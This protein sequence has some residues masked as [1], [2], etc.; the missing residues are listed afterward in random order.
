MSKI[1]LATFVVLRVVAAV[2]AE[3]TEAK[4]SVYTD[5]RGQSPGAI[6]KITPAD[7]PKPYVSKSALNHARLV[8]RPKNAWPQAAPGFKVELYAEGLDNPRLIRTAPNGDLFLAE[9]EPG[10]IRVLRAASGA[11]KPAVNEVYASGLNKPFGIAF[12]PPGPH[13]RYVYIGDTD[14]VLRFPYQEGDRKARSAPEVIVPDIPS[15]GRLRGGGHWTRD[16]AFSNDGKRM[17]VSVGSHSNDAE[18]PNVSERRR[19]DI[20]EYNPD[21]TGFRFYATGIR[22]AVGIAI[23]PGTGDLWASVNERDD[24]GDNLVPDYITRVQ[25]GGFYG[26]PWFYMGNHYDPAHVGKHPE[27]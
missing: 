22:N 15:G 17:F 20:L 10:R 21:G 24:L 13:P 3:G 9:S 16:V 2:A 23:Q 14:A 18:N 11:S 8:P 1:S 5:F 25:D 12:Y 6:H 4:Q 7:L 26:W 27:L 19:A